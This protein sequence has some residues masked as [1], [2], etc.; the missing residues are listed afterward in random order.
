MA[1]ILYSYR[2]MQF[3]C[4]VP[5]QYCKHL[6]PAPLSM[7]PSVFKT[8]GSI[9]CK[10]HSPVCRLVASSNLFSIFIPAFTRSLPSFLFLTHSAHSL[11]GPA[12]FP[13]TPQLNQL[14]H[15]HSIRRGVSP[16]DRAAAASSAARVAPCY[17]RNWNGSRNGQECDAS[18]GALLLLLLAYHRLHWNVRNG[19]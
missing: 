18:S 14:R 19:I 8:R 9:N 6:Q 4:A 13:F 15:A 11:A 2:E 10:I 3:I 16:V 7:Q 1:A 5:V 12:H 17:D